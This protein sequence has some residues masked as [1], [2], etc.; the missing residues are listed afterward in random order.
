MSVGPRDIASNTAKMAVRHT[1]EKSTIA[2]D[3][4]AI[5]SNV[6]TA[7]TQIHTELLEAARTRL[8]AGTNDVLTYADMKSRILSTNV[9]DSESENEIVESSQ[10]E[11]GK[12]R[13]AGFYRVAWKCDRE[14]EQFIK[15]DCKATIR[16]YPLDLNKAPPPEGVKCF[17]S[18]DQAT[19]IAIFARAF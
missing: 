1:G 13:K 12:E 9:K 19:H 2:L 17:Y 4:T 7:L 5:V 15:E 8:S 14:N 6:R 10:G 11:E 18:G 16:C 3:E